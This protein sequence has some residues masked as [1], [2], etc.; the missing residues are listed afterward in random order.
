MLRLSTLRREAE[1]EHFEQGG[2]AGLHVPCSETEPVVMGA[3]A[4][5]GGQLCSS[6]EAAAFNALFRGGCLKWDPVEHVMLSDS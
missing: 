2:S 4:R 6:G 1:K 5:W 3:G